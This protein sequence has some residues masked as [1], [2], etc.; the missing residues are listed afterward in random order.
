MGRVREF[1]IF[2]KSGLSGIIKTRVREFPD[3]SLVSIKHVP[4]LA[5][6]VSR[7]CIHRWPT[8]N[9][10]RR[11]TEGGKGSVIMKSSVMRVRNGGSS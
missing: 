3:P 10:A 11:I 2:E 7:N 5:A 8:N 4:V 6:Q 1:P 9:T